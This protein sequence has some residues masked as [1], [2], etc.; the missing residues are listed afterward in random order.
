[1]SRDRY[2]TLFEISNGLIGCNSKLLEC[3]N[4]FIPIVE[5]KT[6][7]ISIISIARIPYAKDVFDWFLSPVID[8][9]DIKSESNL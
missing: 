8:Y 5:D 9:G 4:I 3:A 7:F 6:L 2:I 1:H